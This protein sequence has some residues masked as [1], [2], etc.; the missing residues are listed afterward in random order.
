MDAARTALALAKTERDAATRGWEAAVN[1]AYAVLLDRLGK[2]TAERHF[3][4]SAR[5]KRDRSG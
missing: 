1:H 5:Q 4:R 3:P 2:R